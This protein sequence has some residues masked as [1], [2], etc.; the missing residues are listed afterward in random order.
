[1]QGPGTELTKKLVFPVLRA[2]QFHAR[3]GSEANVTRTTSWKVEIHKVILK[4]GK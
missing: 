4:I 2:R 1:M 3:F